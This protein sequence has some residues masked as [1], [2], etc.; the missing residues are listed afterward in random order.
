ME[1]IAGARRREPGSTAACIAA[2]VL[3]TLAAT[4]RALAAIDNG[5]FASD[6]EGWTTVVSE[7]ANRITVEPR[8]AAGIR[9]A[10]L[11]QVNRVTANPPAWHVNLVWKNRGLER[12]QPATAYVLRFRARASSP[13]ALRLALA[14]E[15]RP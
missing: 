6:L 1:G 7:P 8:P 10:A 5:D 14:Q 2:I 3:M 13:R 4:G 15:Y 12:L 11:M 9:F